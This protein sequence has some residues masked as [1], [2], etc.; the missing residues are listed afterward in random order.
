[1]IVAGGGYYCCNTKLFRLFINSFFTELQF[2]VYCQLF[3]VKKQLSFVY[4]SSYQSV[5][6]QNSCKKIESNI[7]S[8]FEVLQ[9][10]TQLF[11]NISA[12][13]SKTTILL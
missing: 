11:P 10:H 9:S 4:L 2:F 1:M 7:I 13:I 5:K 6:L 12:D 8:K 3:K